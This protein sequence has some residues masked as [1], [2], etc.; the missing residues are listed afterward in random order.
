MN[1]SILYD[2]GAHHKRIKITFES[3]KGL[4]ILT[5]SPMPF[6]D[7]EKMEYVSYDKFLYERRIEE[8]PIISGYIDKLQA[9]DFTAIMNSTE[10]FQVRGYS[11]VIISR[12]DWGHSFE[13]ILRSPE[14]SKNAE[15]KQVHN[16]LRQLFS[17]IEMDDWYDYDYWR[18]KKK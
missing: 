8:S 9:T 7:S 11:K 5:E 3:G 10:P 1:L 14:K 2:P 13:F 16:L 18:K 4:A 6:H 15:A 12:N 17:H